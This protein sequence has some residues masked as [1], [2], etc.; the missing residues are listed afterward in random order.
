MKSHSTTIFLWFSYGIPMVSTR[1]N[2]TRL[3]QSIDEKIRR[4]DLN[5]NLKSVRRTCFME[6]QKALSAMR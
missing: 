5:D 3:D 2:F 6:L 1:F 4:F